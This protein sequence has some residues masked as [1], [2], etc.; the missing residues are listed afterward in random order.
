MEMS[1]FLGIFIYKNAYFPEISKVYFAYF[2][3][4][5]HFS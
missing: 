3:D 1:S 4:L 2:I 5:R